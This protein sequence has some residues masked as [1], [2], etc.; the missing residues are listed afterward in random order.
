MLQR[1]TK[2]ASSPFREFLYLPINTGADRPGKGVRSSTWGPVG[3]GDG[4][5]I[6]VLWGTGVIKPKPPEGRV[7][8]GCGARVGVASATAFDTKP[9][10]TTEAPDAFTWTC[11]EHITKV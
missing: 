6:D 9:Q 3:L 4:H 2:N 5:G 7:A 10:L 11:A 8:T 1:N